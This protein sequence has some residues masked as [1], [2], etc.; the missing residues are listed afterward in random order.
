MAK[1]FST[2]DCV[3]QSCVL[4]L[5]LQQETAALKREHA[6][7]IAGLTAYLQ[8][9]Q[10]EASR[11]ESALQAAE[12]SLQQAKQDLQHSLEQA[13]STEEKL[14]HQLGEVTA[15]LAAAQQALKDS[16]H[17]QETQQQVLRI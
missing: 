17:Q 15:E 9:L 4:L 8:N 12:H 1:L 16:N 2:C 7:S 5:V 3:A 14:T 11:K 10:S 6:S 13:H